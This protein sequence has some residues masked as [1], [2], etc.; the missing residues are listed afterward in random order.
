MGWFRWIGRKLFGWHLKRG[1][2]PLYLRLGTS[3]HLGDYQFIGLCALLLA[4]AALLLAGTHTGLAGFI[5]EK[6]APL[7][8]DL[9]H[10][11]PATIVFGLLATVATLGSWV[12][13][14]ANKRL[15]T[16]D[17]FACEISS[18]CRVGLVTDF[19]EKSAHMHDESPLKGDREPTPIDIKENFTPVYD[20]NASDLQMLDT[21]SVTAITSFYTYRKTM[22]EYL[23]ASFAATTWEA[24]RR[25]HEQMLYMQFLMY[26]NARFAT[27]ELTEFEPERAD[28]LVTIY[29]SELPLFTRL[30]KRHR[31]TDSSNFLYERLR[32]RIRDYDAKV[33]HLLD[34]LRDI[35]S[36]A[37]G[38]RGIDSA[39]IKAKTTAEELERRFTDFRNETREDKQ[40]PVRIAPHS[41]APTVTSAK[42]AARS[43]ATGKGQDMPR[44]G[45]PPPRPS[46]G[47]RQ[48]Y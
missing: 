39:W 2:V 48:H 32:M 7:G 46:N 23:R 37:R 16:V 8:I 31:E 11:T 18:L 47:T 26:E 27:L 22:M 5:K 41:I 33:Q 36:H 12:Y 9:S 28:N 3:R 44:R 14:S 17:L 40:R 10:P 24:A 35:E 43:R 45:P 29:C 13:Q 19:A 42:P 1:P 25:L 21:N 4:A 38:T 30:L 20:E 15:G 6:T 34:A